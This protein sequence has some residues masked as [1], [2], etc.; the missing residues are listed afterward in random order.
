MFFI[1]FNFDKH[2]LRLFF[3]KKK[4]FQ[5]ANLVAKKIHINRKIFFECSVI[6]IELISKINKEYRKIDQP[7]DVISFALLDAK[8]LDLSANGNQ[9]LNQDIIDSIGEI[10]ICYDKIIEQA[11]KYQHSFKRELCFLFVH[12]LLHLLGYDHIKKQDEVKMFSLQEEI[13]NELRI[14]R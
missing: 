10:Y 13:L 9:Q 4:L 11:K 1:N 14:L 7:T 8:K 5:I 3:Y 12:G 2:K 6:N